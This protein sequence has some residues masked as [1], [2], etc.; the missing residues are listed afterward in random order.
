MTNQ[1]VE[2]GLLNER[3][4]G[5]DPST[6]LDKLPEWDRRA[7][8]HLAQ[9]EG[10][11]LGREHWEVIH[12]LRRRFATRGQVRYARQL[13]HELEAEF[14]DRGGRRHLYRLFPDGPVSQGCRIA[15]LPLP[16]Y[17]EDTSFGSVL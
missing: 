1:S 15:G 8:E 3:S 13:L 9:R 14:A 2:M 10:I 17:H 11:D 6:F 16:D 5:Q 12:F 4:V 7:G